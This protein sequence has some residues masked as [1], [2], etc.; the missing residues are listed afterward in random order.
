[1]YSI[2]VSLSTIEYNH[3]VPPAMEAFWKGLRKDL[4]QH[5]GQTAGRRDRRIVAARRELARRSQ[6]PEKTLTGFMNDHQKSLTTNVVVALFNEING[7]KERYETALGQHL[8]AESTPSPGQ[9]QMYVQMDFQFGGFDD[10][11]QIV[12]ARLPAGREGTVSVRLV[13]RYI[14]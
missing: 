5:Y 7:L 2:I 8:S 3:Y 11:P 12:T 10:S 1:L 14:A 13:S 4:C 6:V 9:Q